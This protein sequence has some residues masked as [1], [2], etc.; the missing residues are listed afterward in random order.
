[1]DEKG[2]SKKDG[3][4]KAAKKTGKKKIT[5]TSMMEVKSEKLGPVIEENFLD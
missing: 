4:Q 3:K 5:G 2:K 1:M